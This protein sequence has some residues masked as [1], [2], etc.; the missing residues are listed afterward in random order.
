MII[1]YIT[2]RFRKID[3]YY[4][5]YVINDK[6]HTAKYPHTHIHTSTDKTDTVSIRLVGCIKA[7]ILVMMLFVLLI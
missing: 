3:I 6:L 7:N 4:Q 1:I 2:T 5:S